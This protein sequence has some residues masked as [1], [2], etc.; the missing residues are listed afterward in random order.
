MSERLDVLL[1]R[2]T[3]ANSFARRPA[4]F[5]GSPEEIL[6]GVKLNRIGFKEW[7]VPVGAVIDRAYREKKIVEVA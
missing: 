7:R 4:N 3:E 1:G 6:S 2:P 5:A